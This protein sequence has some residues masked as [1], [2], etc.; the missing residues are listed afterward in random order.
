MPLQVKA[1]SVL[2]ISDYTGVELEPS[3]NRSEDIEERTKRKTGY[4]MSREEIDVLS[5]IKE[6][7]EEGEERQSKEMKRED[8]V[9]DEED[10]KLWS[11]E[12]KERDEQMERDHTDHTTQNERELKNEENQDCSYWE[13][14]VLPPQ[15][16]SCL[17]TDR[18]PPCPVDINRDQGVRSPCRQDELTPMVQERSWRLKGQVV[19]CKRE[20]MSSLDKPLTDASEKDICAEP[21]LG[22]SV[23]SSRKGDTGETGEVSSHAFACSQCPFVH[24]EKMNLHQHIEKVHPEEYSRILGSG[25]NGAEDPLPPSSTPQNPTPPKTLPTL[26]ESHTGTLCSQPMAV[27]KA[28]IGRYQRTADKSVH[29]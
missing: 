5:S 21:F 26:T 27:N 13:K 17:L 28:N 19:T 11:E 16:T 25:G 4:G 7:E 18:S 1:E 23:I 24:T 9:S 29:P 2:D 20:M 12:G 3:L 22:S 8:G 10:K 6:E 15:V 14:K